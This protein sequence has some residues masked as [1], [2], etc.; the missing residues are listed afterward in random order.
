MAGLGQRCLLLRVFSRRHGEEKSSDLD[1]AT[2][3]GRGTREAGEWLRRAAGGENVGAEGTVKERKRWGRWPGRERGDML[4]WPR[5]TE[6]GQGGA[7]EGT[8]EESTRDSLSEA[9][10]RLLGGGGRPGE[11]PWT[12][13]GG[14]A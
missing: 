14:A 3:W 8:G 13:G 6:P 5:G 2:I 1:F 12:G 4:A 11:P 9:A 10:G 7:Q